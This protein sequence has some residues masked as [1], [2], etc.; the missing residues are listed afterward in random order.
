MAT[1]TVDRP[2][3]TGGEN[4]GVDADVEGLDDARRAAVSASPPIG[5]DGESGQT[6]APAS[7][8]TSASR[9]TTR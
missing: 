3:R 6:T 7:P 8:A 2:D 4:A 5:E 9:P 1:E